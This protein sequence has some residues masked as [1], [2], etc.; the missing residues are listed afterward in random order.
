MSIEKTISLIDQAKK[1]EVIEVAS[2]LI[3]KDRLAVAILGQVGRNIQ[4]KINWNLV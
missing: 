4:Q 1:E 3:R 2:E